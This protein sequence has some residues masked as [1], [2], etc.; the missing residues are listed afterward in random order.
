[1]NLLLDKLPVSLTIDN[2]I[3][4]IKTNFRDWIRFETVMLN[5][6][7][8]N[9]ERALLLSEILIDVPSDINKA[10]EQLIWFYQCGKNEEGKKGKSSAKKVYDYEVDQFLIHTAFIQYYKIDLNEIEYLH[11]WNFRQMFLE[12]PDD[13]KVKKAMMY[14]TVNINQKMSKEQRQF[15]AE[16][17]R[18]Y[19]LP[20]HRTEKQ[21][22]N[23]IGSILAQ[24]MKVRK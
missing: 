2:H 8:T 22:A 10:I 7:S 14:R 15:Y 18:L 16:M 5:V 11:W 21:K 13:S 9:Q 24:G 6:E 19:A 20:D 3:F 17:K 23:S 12:L 4:A 1:M